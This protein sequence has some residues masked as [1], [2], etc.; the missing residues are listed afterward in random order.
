MFYA[1]FMFFF[2]SD[3]TGANRTFTLLVFINLDMTY[4]GSSTERNRVSSISPL[5]PSKFCAAARIPLIGKIEMSSN[6]SHRQL[7]VCLLSF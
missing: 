4:R 5:G 1:L 7:N 3:G 6:T 2:E